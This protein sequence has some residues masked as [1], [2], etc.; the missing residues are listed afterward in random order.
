M[1]LILLESPSIKED[2]DVNWVRKTAHK[3][4]EFTDKECKVV[5]QLANALRHFVPKRRPREDGLG[6][7]GSLPCMVL[8]APLVLIANTIL[9]ATGYTRFTRRIAPQISP[10]DMHGLHLGAVGVYET[11]CSENERQFDILD[12]NGLPLVNRANVTAIPGNKDAVFASIFDLN[13]IKN[14]CKTH[15]LEFHDR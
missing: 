1:L 13:K 9:A 12:K 15:G 10:A 6:F 11:L 2:I 3:H 14:I 8:R 7:Q 5:A 4:D